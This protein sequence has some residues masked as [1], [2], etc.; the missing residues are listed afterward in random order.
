[1]PKLSIRLAATAAIC[2]L[3]LT[4]FAQTSSAPASSYGGASTGTQANASATV[5]LKAG[6]TVKDSTGAMV[7]KI[8]KVANDTATIKMS[9]G[10]FSAPTSSLTVEGGA[11]TIN[12]TKADIDAQVQGGSSKKTPG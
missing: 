5:G 3:P 12:M 7:G 9:K 11:A 10:T 6:M 8:S 1:M 2:V 4:G